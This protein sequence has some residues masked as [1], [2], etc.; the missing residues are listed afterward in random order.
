M[1]TTTTTIRL[2]HLHGFFA[3]VAFRRRRRVSRRLACSLDD[4]SGSRTNAMS[5]IST[6]INTE[7]YGLCKGLVGES[8]NQS[9]VRLGYFWRL[10]Y[11]HLETIFISSRY[12]TLSSRLQMALFAWTMDTLQLVAMT[13]WCFDV[14]FNDILTPRH[15]V[16]HSKSFNRALNEWQ[17]QINAE[18]MTSLRFSILLLSP[19][20]ANPFS[21]LVLLPFK[22]KQTKTFLSCA[23]RFN[24]QHICVCS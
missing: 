11:L 20:R 17:V 7:M 9:P 13:P 4:G 18:F 2:C 22:K 10:S 6:Q 12:S 8:T 15:V 3:L 24:R 23:G 5:I 21:S 14:I 19:I 16:S 1:R